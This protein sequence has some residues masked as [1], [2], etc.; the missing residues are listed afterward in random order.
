MKRRKR[1]LDGTL[2]ELEEVFPEGLS[3][4][5]ISLFD[6]LADLDAQREADKMAQDLAL[7]ELAESLLVG[8]NL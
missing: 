4:T 1:L 3:T 6:A 5:E 2:G 7:A 8:G